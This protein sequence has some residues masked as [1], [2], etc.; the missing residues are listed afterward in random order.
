MGNWSMVISQYEKILEITPNFWGSPKSMLAEIIISGHR[1][2]AGK[3]K[4]ELSAGERQR[5]LTWI[6]LNVPYYGSSVTNNPR[7]RG[8]RQLSVRDL[9]NVLGEVA[10]RRCASC[11]KG[12]RLPRG[13]RL[14]FTNPRNNAFLLAPLAK[15][16]GGTGKCGQAVFKGTGDPDYRKILKVFEPLGETLRKTPRIDMPGAKPMCEACKG[17][18]LY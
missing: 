14:R 17:N 6:D 12:G 4:V 2:A 3:A 16:A 11:H 13:N 15:S 18:T 7:L 1:D 8:G 5:I 9:R 10:R